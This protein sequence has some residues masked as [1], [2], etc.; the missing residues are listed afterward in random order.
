MNQSTAC[1][2]TVKGTEFAFSFAATL[3]DKKERKKKISVPENVS[4]RR[5]EELPAGDWLR[6]E[7]AQFSL[8]DIDERRRSEAGG[9][10]IVE[11]FRP[12]A[13]G[14]TPRAR[15]NGRKKKKTPEKVG[16]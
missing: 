12:S 1:D 14:T 2:N 3:A 5:E 4:T 16:A 8:S 7:V 15:G 13:S 10:A 9:L 11:I 6:R